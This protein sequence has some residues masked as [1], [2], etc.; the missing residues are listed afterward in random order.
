MNEFN[1]IRDENQLN[2]L[3]DKIWNF[4]DSFISKIN[5]TVGPIDN[6]SKLVIKFEYVRYDEDFI[7]A[8]ELK[9]EKIEKVFIAPNED[10]YDSYIFGAKIVLKYG[11]FI[12]VNDESLDVDKIL[13]NEKFLLLYLI[14][15]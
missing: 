6:T 14:L 3:L 9:F 10:N 4:H 13:T 15:L 12:F 1:K 7:D 2:E 11:K 5:Y 8:L